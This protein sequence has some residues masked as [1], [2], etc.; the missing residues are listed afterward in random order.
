MFDIL[1]MDG[2]SQNQTNQSNLSSDLGFLYNNP[3]SQSSNTFQ[4]NTAFENGQNA[5]GLPKPPQKPP[6][7]QP[8]KFDFPSSGQQNVGIDLFASL[9]A[10]SSAPQPQN[11]NQTFGGVGSGTQSST[12]NL[13]KFR[14]FCKSLKI[15]FRFTILS[16]VSP[17][18]IFLWSIP[19]SIYW[20]L[21]WGTEHIRFLDSAT[22]IH[23]RTVPRNFKFRWKFSYKPS[24]NRYFRIYAKQSKL[25]RRYSIYHGN[26]GLKFFIPKQC[27]FCS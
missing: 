27:Y 19:A 21:W 23:S 2:P 12:S 5:F 9:A 11:Y 17:S 24:N 4:S 8:E 20:W 22:P 26:S 13:G 25:Q 15:K 7:T 18:S 16:N 14:I 6:T 1:D 3:T 10:V